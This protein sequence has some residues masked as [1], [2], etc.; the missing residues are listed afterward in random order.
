MFTNLVKASIAS[1]PN[2]VSLVAHEPH[3]QIDLDDRGGVACKV[4]QEAC[5]KRFGRT[6][7]EVEKS[8]LDRVNQCAL[9]VDQRSKI[10]NPA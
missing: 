9:T 1:A 2:K 6:V 10:A 7:I 3:N 5:P 8:L 4:Q